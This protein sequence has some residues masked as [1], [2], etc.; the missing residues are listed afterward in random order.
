LKQRGLEGRNWA[1]SDEAKFTAQ[2]M[3]NSIIEGIEH[4]LE[5]FVPR[6]NFDIIKL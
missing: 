2:K 4:T 6:K 1:I 5:K 3:T